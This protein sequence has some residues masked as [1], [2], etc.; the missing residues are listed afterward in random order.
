MNANIQTRLNILVVAAVLP[1]LVL[2]GV[3]LS[4]RVNDDHAKARSDVRNA[5]TLAA[6]RIDDYFNNMNTLLI[7]IGRVTSSD[8]ADIEKNDAIL[9]AVKGDLPAYLNNVLVFDLKGDSLGTSQWPLAANSRISVGDRDYFKAA[10]EGKVTIS[11]PIVSRLN[12]NWIVAIARPVLNDA[13]AVRSI[14]VTGTQLARITEITESASLPQGS[15]VRILTER[16]IVVGRTDHP[17]W[18]GRN[19]SDDPLIRRQ[20]ALGGASEETD[21]LDGI[22]RVTASV[23]ARAVPWV[24]TVGLPTDTWAIA[25]KHMRLGLM[26]TVLAITSAFLL[27][28]GFSS[29]IVRPIRQ[30]RRD[31]ATIGAGKFDHRSSVQTTGELAQLAGAFNMMADSLLQAKEAAE[32]ATRAKSEF[33]SVMSHEIRTPLNGVIGMIG[34]LADTR[35]D[36]KQRNYAEM[37]GQSGEALL[38]VVNDILDFSKIEAGKVELEII[39]FNLHDIVESVAAMVAVRAAAKGLE[40]ASLIDHDLPQTVR[41]DPFRLRQILANL[42]GN[43]IKFTERG[44]VVLRAR[45]HAG[46]K[47]GV[48]IRFEV[49]DTGIGVSPEKRSRLFEAF[50]QA[51]PS[52]TRKHGG[53]GL[54]LAISAQLVRLMGGEIGVDSDPGKGSTFWFSIPL[55]LSSTQAPRPRMDLRGLRVLAVDDNAVNRTI[56]HEHIVG[57]QMRNGSAESGAR[58]LDMLRAAAARGE[59]YDVAIVDM[60]MPG[61]DGLA[62]ARAIKADRSIEGTRLILLSSIGQTGRDPN[63]DGFFDACLTKPAPQ[64]QL[65]DCMARVMA[66]PDAA[67]RE[68]P[69]AEVPSASRKRAKVAPRADRILIAEDNVVNQQ[70]ALGVLATLGYRADVVA[71]G[72]EAVEAAALVPYDA[73]LM[74]C[75]MPEMDGYQATQE[76]RR[77][78]GTGRHTPI[79]ALTADVLKDARAK[80]L[81]AGMDDHITKP[82]NPQELA[83]ALDR[84]L[85]GIGELESRAVAAAPRPEGAVDPTVL[86]G[87]RELERAGAPG[88]VKKITDLFLLDTPRQVADLWDSLRRGDSVRLVKVAHTLKGSAANL[89]ARKMA[90][91]CAELEVLGEAQNIGIAPS[92]VADLESQFESVRDALLSKRAKV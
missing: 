80:S 26:L 45:R 63:R 91:I 85:P 73:I 52:T 1:L 76:I 2:A 50:A 42:A 61:M 53:T 57:W 4:Q 33:L 41:G 47:D 23:T 69:R 67:E 88:L 31:A 55:G 86:D 71:N 92:L 15:A 9:R 49:S 51:D 37:A 22:T 38:D 16:G 32:A 20:L 48:T 28:W 25:S 39:D 14:L 82:L 44:E 7:M 18:I 59:P 83:A 54:G 75:Q 66:K 3:F 90:R 60:Q 72:R 5:A 21:W 29:G 36:P 64:S 58:A 8:P 68:L 74:D 84:W 46:T 81:S 35:L 12:H 24:V 30:L 89:G 43:A 78:E 6:A 13:G 19:L 77:R 65:Y 34:L 40:L 62:L 70:V 10:L 17:D 79:L 87:L 56:L 27:A 11:E